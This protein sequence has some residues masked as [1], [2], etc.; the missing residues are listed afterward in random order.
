MTEI[1]GS[2]GGRG[3]IRSLNRRGT[4]TDKGPAVAHLNVKFK[5]P[6]IC[7]KCGAIYL[8]RTWRRDH[9]LSAETMKQAA[10]AV[11]PS[12]RQVATH[13]HFGRV[14]LSG[15]Y[16][17]PHL[18]AITRRINNVSVRAEFTQPERKLVAMQWQGDSYEVLTT[19]QKLAHRIAHELEKAFGGHA[20]YSWSDGDGG[21]LAN[22][23][24][25]LKSPA[26]TRSSRAR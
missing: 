23:H 1:I 8:R 10:W 5:E 20:A 22:W 14:L 26:R 6:T 4:R 7:D 17:A 18:G 15:D 13:E 11:C 24:C 3:R 25:D 19:S 21:L 12:C 16:V 9:H 2:T